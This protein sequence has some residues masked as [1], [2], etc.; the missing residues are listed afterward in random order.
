MTAA[1]T[2]GALNLDCGVKLAVLR[3]SWAAIAPIPVHLGALIASASKTTHGTI[4]S[5]S[6][7]N[8]VGACAWSMLPALG[9]VCCFSTQVCP[10]FA[11]NRLD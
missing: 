9:V 8:S 3:V 1:C 4:R 6:S 7:K 10:P 11:Y 2:S 5:I